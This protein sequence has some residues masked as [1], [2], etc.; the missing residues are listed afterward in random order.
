[1]LYHFSYVD[2]TVGPTKTFLFQ[3]RRGP[4]VR[5]IS[6]TFRQNHLD[7]SPYTYIFLF[8]FIYLKI[9]W[10][11]VHGPRFGIENLESRQYLGGAI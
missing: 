11:P 3:T 10:I 5:T 6:A 2:S 8:M 1:M 7:S 4:K 9:H